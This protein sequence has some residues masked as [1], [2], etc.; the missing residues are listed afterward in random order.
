MLGFLG[1]TSDV[2]L[3]QY[4]NGARTPKAD[5]V[6]EIA[7]IFDVDPRALTVPDIDTYVG[8]M[9]TFFA[10][11]DMYGLIISENDSEVCL[12]SDKITKLISTC[13]NLLLPGNTFERN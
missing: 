5:L 6:K 11:E 4:E 12:R 2:R 9:H 8:L 1:K 7:N 13:L 10:L 3:A